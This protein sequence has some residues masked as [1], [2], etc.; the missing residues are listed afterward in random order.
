M[1]Q[2]GGHERS[3]HKSYNKSKDL[4]DYGHLPGSYSVVSTKHGVAKNTLYDVSTC[5]LGYTPAEPF[6]TFLAGLEASPSIQIPRTLLPI[7]RRNPSTYLQNKCFILLGDSTLTETSFDIQLLM[8]SGFDMQHDFSEYFKT[9]AYNVTHQNIYGATLNFNKSTNTFYPNNRHYV[10][11]SAEFNSSIYFRFNGHANIKKN[12]N[13]IVHTMLN[14][15]VQFE[16]L[17]GA[18]KACQGRERIVWLQTGYHDINPSMTSYSQLSK[19]FDF[20]E[21]EIGLN[22]PNCCFFLNRQEPVIE[23]SSL[24]KHHI[25]DQHLSMKKIYHL[26]HKLT[27]ERHERWSFINYT[28]AFTCFVNNSTQSTF[29][30]W[31][32]IGVIARGYTTPSYRQFYL[33][34][35]QTMTALLHTFSS[36]F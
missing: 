3:Y 23:M 5:Q 8:E 35:F 10:V 1:V 19:V 17:N 12:F 11:Q 36:R 9:W 28:E 31:G 15:D 29:G 13:G 7:L 21:E 26:A 14:T 20:V 22:Q 6:A 25:P 2:V 24:R 27:L 32:H 33:S 18:E 34:I 30:V 16:I 4:L